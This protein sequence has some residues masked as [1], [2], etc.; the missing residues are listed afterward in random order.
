MALGDRI[1]VLY[2]GKLIYVGKFN[3]TDEPLIYS[4]DKKWCITLENEKTTYFIPF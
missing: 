2:K 3:L 4:G 1:G